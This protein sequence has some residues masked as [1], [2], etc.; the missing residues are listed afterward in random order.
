MQADSYELL[1]LIGGALSWSAESNV[2]NIHAYLNAQYVKVLKGRYLSLIEFLDKNANLHKLRDLLIFSLNRLSDDEFTYALTSPRLSGA[3]RKEWDGWGAYE[4][5]AISYDF[6]A[7]GVEHE[8]FLSETLPERNGGQIWGTRGNCL[9]KIDRQSPIIAKQFCHSAQGIPLNILCGESIPGIS[10]LAEL[11]LPHAWEAA[12]I[13]EK[14]ERALANLE[15][16]LPVAFQYCL[17]SIGSII[18][19]DTAAGSEYSSASCDGWMGAIMLTNVQSKSVN[20]LSV[21]E[22]ILHEAVHLLIYKWEVLYGFFFDRTSL[23]YAESPW[24]GQK[25]L[26]ENYVHA[27]FVWFSLLSLWKNIHGKGVFDDDLVGMYMARTTEGWKRGV[28]DNLGAEH[29]AKLPAELT[30]ILFDLEAQAK[31]D[32]RNY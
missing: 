1:S 2:R 11:R 16:G 13:V 17:Q 4:V 3:L 12:E 29:R 32:C 8:I 25:I 9:Y 28:I 15:N 6:I 24:T 27:C 14:I 10:N 23:D 20:L 19:R 5:R 26:L 30:T 7:A 18:V 21:V 22:S 31:A